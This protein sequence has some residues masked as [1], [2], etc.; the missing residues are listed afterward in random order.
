M[1][2]VRFLCREPKKDALNN[3]TAFAYDPAGNRT[4]RT[5]AKA[6]ATTYAYDTINR[7][8]TVTYPA[9]QGSVTY[10][11]CDYCSVAIPVPA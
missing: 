7:L 6:Q 9:G 8:T 5:D 11:Y 1:N 10:G 2:P 4:K 3:I